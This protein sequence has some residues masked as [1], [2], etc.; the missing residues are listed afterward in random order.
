M[1]RP[2][3]IPPVP[4]EW[5]MNGNPEPDGFRWWRLYKTVASRMLNR[6]LT[7][8]HPVRIVPIKTDGIRCGFLPKKPDDIDVE[9]A[10]M[11]RSQMMD[12]SICFFEWEIGDAKRKKKGV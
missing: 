4:E 6:A 12:A 1:I 8:F 7:E 10:A 9:I 5:V 3:I 11:A 2:L